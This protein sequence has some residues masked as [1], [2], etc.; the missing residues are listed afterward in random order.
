MAKRIK[1]EKDNGLIRR[2]GWFFYSLR[3]KIYHALPARFKKTRGNGANKRNE[4]LFI[5]SALAIPLFVFS[6]FYIGVNIN[7]ILLAFKEYDLDSG[8]FVWAS[9]AFV[10][11]TDF[12]DKL[13]SEDFMD[14]SIKNSVILFCVSLFFNLPFHIFNAYYIYKK[15]FLHGP[16]KVL[17]FL[18]SVISSVVTVTMFKYFLI[19]GLN[20][21]Y[22]MFGWGVAPQFLYNV[23]TGFTT[24]IV[25]SCWISFGG[26][27]ILFLGLMNRI[28][29]SV[30]E[31]A[32]LDGVNSFQ[33]FLY[34][35]LPLIFPTI[36]IYVI[37]LI[38][39]FF[40]A[41]GS[42]FTFYGQT[43]R[44]EYYTFGYY[45]YINVLGDS[46]VSKYPMAA[47]SGVVFTLV[48]AP[49]TLLARRILN[50]LYPP[51]DY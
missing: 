39:G 30:T 12:F 50:K 37:N 19:Y 33:E 28:S 46:G 34:I 31:A 2:I 6:V 40:S 7:C 49:I 48:V 8:K 14:Y 24:T 27:M 11:F 38:A 22:K 21:I 16:F 25:Y 47:A 20:D 4:R 32:A 45:Y 36:S 3:C 13:R 1:Q 18:P 5:I 44:K 29:P 17:L 51:I 15:K 23:E 41:Q 9:K 26:S 42:L 43:A 10:N 35:V